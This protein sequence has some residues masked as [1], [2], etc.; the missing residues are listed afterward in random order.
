[1]KKKSIWSTCLP[2]NCFSGTG[3]S[4]PL[5][6]W[7]KFA[8]V[9]LQEASTSLRGKSVMIKIPFKT[10][11]NRLLHTGTWR[12]L[13]SLYEQTVLV[14]TFRFSMQK[15]GFTLG[16]LLWWLQVWKS[17]LLPTLSWSPF[18]RNHLSLESFSILTPLLCMCKGSLRVLNVLLCEFNTHKETKSGFSSRRPRT[19]SST[20]VL[21]TTTVVVSKRKLKS[22]TTCS[23]D[24]TGK[25]H[26]TGTGGA[27]P[28]PPK[29]LSLQVPL[30]SCNCGCG[31]NYN[32]LTVSFLVLINS[33]TY[34]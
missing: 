17:P 26:A 1:M 11:N 16:S 31:F 21:Q 25:S 18:L 33:H 29:T 30:T 27:Q 20:S 6:L 7:L 32:S 15:V 22:G 9:T 13:Y 28:A 2:S 19:V 14:L 3:R 23:C 34:P 10:S 24:T 4:P 8:L 5:I 12:K